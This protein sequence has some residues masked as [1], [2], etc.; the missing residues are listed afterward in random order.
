MASVA[1]PRDLFLAAVR[2]AVPAAVAALAV[3]ALALA[4]LGVGVAVVG[5]WG[6]RPSRPFAQQQPAQ[7][8]RRFWWP[9]LATSSWQ[10]S[11]QRFQ[12]QWQHWQWQHC[13]WRR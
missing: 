10:Q 3:A 2:A 8:T 6:G 1:V 12:R 9:P 4:A 11:E 13:R 7:R 5:G